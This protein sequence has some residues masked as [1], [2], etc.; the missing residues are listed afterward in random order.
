MYAEFSAAV[1][2]AFKAEA[3][4]K[5]VSTTAL[6]NKLSGIELGVSLYI[7]P[8]PIFALAFLW[9]EKENIEEERTS[10]LID[11]PMGSIPSMTLEPTI[12]ENEDLDM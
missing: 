1:H 6:Y 11:T 10:L 8:F 7:L 3:I 9:I 4:E 2:A 12:E 5:I